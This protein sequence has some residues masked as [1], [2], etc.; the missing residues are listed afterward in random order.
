MHRRVSYLN[1]LVKD[2]DKKEVQNSIEDIKLEVISQRESK[3][4]IVRANKAQ[5]DCS[6]SDFVFDIS[7]VTQ[8]NKGGFPGDASPILPNSKD[9]ETQSFDFQF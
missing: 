2:L 4:G 5:E 9:R 7:K 1:I 8:E 3:K 6:I